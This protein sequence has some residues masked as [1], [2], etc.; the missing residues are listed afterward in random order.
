MRLVLKMQL[1]WFGD[2]GSPLL[3]VP[4]AHAIPDTAGG[5]HCQQAPGPGPGLRLQ[6]SQSQTHLH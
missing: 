6:Q 3:I 4:D 5:G 1:L 2:P